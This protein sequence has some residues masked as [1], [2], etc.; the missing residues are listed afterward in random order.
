[1]LFNYSYQN[2]KFN[3]YFIQF[4]HSYSLMPEKSVTPMIKLS[5]FSRCRTKKKG[6]LAKAIIAT[7]I[8][9]TVNN[10]TFRNN[11]RTLIE[12]AAHKDAEE[13]SKL[14][15]TILLNSDSNRICKRFKKFSLRMLSSAL[16]ISKKKTNKSHQRLWLE[17]PIVHI[18]KL[19]M[20]ITT[21][22]DSFSGI[23]FIESD[24]CKQVAT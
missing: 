21:Q 9:R 20:N 12:L 10:L 3:S 8:S 16:K 23:S 19:K 18:G 7:I 11:L 22:E 4:L 24:T 15:S 13:S 2:H 17:F 6:K 14:S 5:M 1:M